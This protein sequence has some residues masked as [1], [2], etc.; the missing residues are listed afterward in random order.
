MLLK[1]GLICAEVME[2]STLK[3]GDVSQYPNLNEVYSESTFMKTATDEELID[4]SII[5][6]TIVSYALPKKTNIAE[7][8]VEVVD[9]TTNI[10]LDMKNPLLDCRLSLF[11]GYYID[12]LYKE[13]EATF[14]GV[15]KMLVNSLNSE[16]LSL[17]HQSSDTL[18]TIISDK[19]LVP[20]ITPHIPDLIVF[21]NQCMATVNIPDFFTFV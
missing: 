19:D 16:Q 20:R 8:F 4:T 14:L 1:T 3:Q 10:I 2:Y 6:L 15:L 7:K 9:K 17:A 13:D 12:I 18:N 11:L 5:V 21:V